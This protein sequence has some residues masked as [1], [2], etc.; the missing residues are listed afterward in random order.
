M[1]GRARCPRIAA[2]PWLAEHGLIGF[3]R[4]ERFVRH[5]RRLLRVIHGQRRLEALFELA[6]VLIDRLAAAPGLLGL[7][8]D[9]PVSA[10]EDGG[11]VA[12]DGAKR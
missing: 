9:G 5:F 1:N 6:S 2:A 11:R 10:R 4:Y 3:G 8:S 12:D 7:A